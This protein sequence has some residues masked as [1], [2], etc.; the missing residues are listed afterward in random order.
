[1]H[2]LKPLLL[3]A[4]LVPG[5][6][7]AALDIRITE[8]VTGAI[9]IAI[10]P[11]SA[12]SS[13]PLAEDVSAIVTANLKRSGRFSPISR[14]KFAQPNAN[15]GNIELYRWR[16]QS[17]DYVVVGD[18]TETAE[19]GYVVKFQLFD[20]GAG[21]QL[22]GYNVPANAGEL[23]M[24]AH[25][26]SDLIYEAILN[27]RGAFNTR[28]A[29]IT[30]QISGGEREYVLKVSDSDGHNDR[31]VLNSSSPLMSP[32]WSPD[33]RRIAYVSFEGNRS[34]IYVQ[35]ISTGRR[36]A[37]S[38]RKGINGAPVWSPDG[39]N[40][41]ITLSKSGAP[42][43]YI[44]N[45]TSRRLTKVTN[46]RSIDT[47]PAWMPDG[48][49]IIFTSNRS[50]KPQLYKVA[51]TGGSAQRLTFDGEYNS[52]PSVSPDGS[53]VAMVN[54]DDGRFR[55]AVLDLDSGETSILT[56]GTLDESPSFA[57]NGSMILYATEAGG[58]GVLA[59]V[60]DDGRMRQTL[61]LQEGE[62]REPDWSAFLN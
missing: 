9:P 35:E 39:E 37:V 16:D 50:G 22:A 8:G 18:V 49:S 15:S 42:N 20:S 29:Y 24:A 5:W 34:S 2:F 47:E 44:L 30:T 61:V 7:H 19:G 62:V 53:K 54:G 23:R 21:N 12:I 58:R 41:A 1:M 13:S 17:I 55:I 56:N 33:N 60:S 51:A 10:A 6:L 40:L 32:A 43:I 14:D 46:N 31:T 57:P 52:A 26:V 59:A 27:V 4:L 38:S 25:Q 3:L 28:I 36:Q 48:Q 45:V 11:F